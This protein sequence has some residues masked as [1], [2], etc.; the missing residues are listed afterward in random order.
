LNPMTAE[1]DTERLACNY[2]AIEMCRQRLAPAYFNRAVITAE[3]C[4]PRQALE[5]GFLDF[6]V[7]A[8]ELLSAARD[9]ATALGRLVR[10]AYVATKRGARD[11]VLQALRRALEADV[12]EWTTQI[13]A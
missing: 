3:P 2:S 1:Q 6:L 7:P 5:A 11:G 10:D 8:P 12:A 9:K 13:R 4:D